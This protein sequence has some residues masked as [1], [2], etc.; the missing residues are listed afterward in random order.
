MVRQL[1]LSEV[2]GGSGAQ[3]FVVLPQL[4]YFLYSPP[5]GSALNQSLLLTG[6]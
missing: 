3:W 2:E 1:V 5:A 6:S 4:V